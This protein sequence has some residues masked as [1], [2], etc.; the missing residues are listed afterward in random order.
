MKT[1]TNLSNSGINTE[2][3]K[4]VKWAGAFVNPKDMTKSL[5]LIKAV[6]GRLPFRVLSFPFPVLPFRFPPPRTV[7]S[8]AFPIPLSPH[9]PFSCSVTIPCF[10]S[11]SSL[12][13]KPIT[14]PTY[15]PRLAKIK[16][17]NKPQGDSNPR[18]LKQ[19]CSHLP[20]H[21]M[22]VYVYIYYNKNIYYISSEA[23]LLPLH[24]V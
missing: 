7:H 18:P 24:N 2:F 16:L 10:L 11:H 13:T 22:C 9:S 1:T 12:P 8:H 6:R 15:I 23:H 21:H 17:K 3:I 5:L 4:Y 20:V 19:M 14:I